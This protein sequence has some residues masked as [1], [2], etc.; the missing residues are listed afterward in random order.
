M[1]ACTWCSPWSCRGRPNPPEL[2]L[3]LLST[4]GLP[5]SPLALAGLSLTPLTFMLLAWLGSNP[6]HHHTKKSQSLVNALLTAGTVRSRFVMDETESESK[7]DGLVGLEALILQGHSI[8]RLPS[9]KNMK[10]MLSMLISSNL[11]TTIAVGDFKGA[12]SLVAIDLGNNKITSVAVEAF[13]NLLAL[14]CTAQNF[15]PE[16]DDGE[17]LLQ[18]AR[19]SASRLCVFFFPAWHAYAHALRPGV[20]SELQ[21]AKLGPRRPCRFCTGTPARILLGRAGHR[22]PE[23]ACAGPCFVHMQRPRGGA[24]ARASH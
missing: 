2:C 15:K 1:V 14:N 11:I 4:S 22:R 5:R 18:T 20:A 16:N 21:L 19:S 6:F 23:R 10:K 13:L 17:G 12:E 8:T 3:Q 24:I 9:V 7:F